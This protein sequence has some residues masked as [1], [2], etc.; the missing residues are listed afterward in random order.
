MTPT[1][2]SAH[3]RSIRVLG[4]TGDVDGKRRRQ[5]RDGATAAIRSPARGKGVLGNLRR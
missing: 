4:G 5:S 1:V 3:Q 2:N